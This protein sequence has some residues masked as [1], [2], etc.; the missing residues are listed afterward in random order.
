MRAAQRLAVSRDVRTAVAASQETALL[1]LRDA[2][3]IDDEA[4]NKLLLELDH[5]MVDVARE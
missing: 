5:A 3:S 1:R 4:Y 2:G